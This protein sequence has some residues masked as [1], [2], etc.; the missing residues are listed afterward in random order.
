M[1]IIRFSDRS[2]MDGIR[3]HYVGPFSSVRTAELWL[4]ENDRTEQR[5]IEQ[6]VDPAEEMF[7]MVVRAPMYPE[8]DEQ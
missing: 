3:Y 2:G 5:E 4:A 1:V 7:G 6:L 8:D